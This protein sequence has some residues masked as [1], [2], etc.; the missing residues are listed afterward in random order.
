MNILIAGANH[1]LGY[2][3]VKY[4]ADR[5]HRTIAGVLEKSD[6]AAVSALAG[7]TVFVC[8]LDVTDDTCVQSAAALT[9]EFLG[10]AQLDVIVN[11]A[12]VLLPNDREKK[13][14]DVPLEEI[15]AT[16]DINAMGNI[17]L[18]KHFLPM[19]AD[20]GKLFLITSE[21][22]SASS[23]WW[24]FPAYSI[25]KTAA[26][27][28]AFVLKASYGDKYDI[29][30]IHPGR[31]KTPMGGAGSEIEPEESAAGIYEL[32]HRDNRGGA[33]FVD[34]LGREMEI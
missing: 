33:A 15:R 6:T 12:G 8:P 31:M 16:F 26:N 3:L 1:G 21:A 23:S 19:L 10:G 27:K 2:S 13:L 25:S 17:I 32:A 18:A 30:A 7:D 29:L 5:G 20:G 11:C 28:I 22:G 34:Y 14:L 24:G 9:C 4:F